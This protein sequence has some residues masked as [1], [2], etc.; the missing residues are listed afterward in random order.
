MS[1]INKWFAAI[2]AMLVAMAS[3]AGPAATEESHWLVHRVRAFKSQSEAEAELK[4]RFDV[5]EFHSEVLMTGALPLSILEQKIRRWI[6]ARKA[7]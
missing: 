4:D 1:S 2:V 7:S 6:A 3:H 5:R